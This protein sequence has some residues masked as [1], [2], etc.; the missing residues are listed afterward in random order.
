MILKVLKELIA[1]F[2]NEILKT[3]SM[4]CSKDSY[5]KEGIYYRFAIVSAI[6]AFMVRAFIP[7]NQTWLFIPCML[8][9][10]LA[11]LFVI[12]PKILK[13]ISLKGGKWIVGGCSLVIGRLALSVSQHLIHQITFVNPANFSTTMV[14]V[15]LF[16][17]L[18]CW[19]IFASIFLMF[20]LVLSMFCL[21][22]KGCYRD[23]F[24]KMLH[25]L[26]CLYLFMFL[27][28]TCDLFN[29]NYRFL[30]NPIER[31]LIAFDYYSISE[32]SN[33]SDSELFT[34]LSNQKI[35]IARFDPSK[36]HYIFREENC[37]L[38]KQQYELMSPAYS[39]YTKKI[40]ES[41]NG[42]LKNTSQSN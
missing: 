6:S 4:F 13:V 11:G 12:T 22:S 28:L 1:D 34:Y 10:M 33:V 25:S 16:T 24:K 27:T 15:T 30:L 21:G 23:N 31:M 41:I 20:Y 32:C 9:L 8:S 7:Y 14:I 36:G 35:S 42:F 26:S 2:I 39:E 40:K 37:L 29:R 18:Y 38:R 17:T 3:I 5:L 19:I